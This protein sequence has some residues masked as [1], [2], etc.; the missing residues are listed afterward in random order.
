MEVMQS[1]FSI[2]TMIGIGVL[3]SWKLEF[4]DKN[5]S[6]LSKLVMS[7]TLPAYM[8]TNISENFSSELLLSMGSWLIVPFATIGFC[9]VLGFLAARLIS[10]PQ[11]PCVR[12]VVPLPELNSR[13]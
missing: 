2:F 3:I 1:V 11:T 7:V 9:Y 13:H 8:I 12:I 6:G 5:S 4:D 10:H